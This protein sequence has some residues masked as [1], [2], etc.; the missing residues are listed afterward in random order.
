MYVTYRTRSAH[1]HVVGDLRDLI[2]GSVR[3]V[4]PG[5]RAGIG[6]QDHASVVLAR[7]D[8]GLSGE[9][10]EGGTQVSV[11][12]GALLKESP[13]RSRASPRARGS[14]GHAPLWRSPPSSPGPRR[15]R[16]ILRTTP[17]LVR[18]APK[19]PEMARTEAQTNEF[20]E[21]E[22]ERRAR[23]SRRNALYGPTAGLELF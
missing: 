10:R 11:R 13:A 21:T 14:N 18:S 23:R 12:S 2:R 22:N 6:A 4:R 16:G 5:G 1:P 7:H 17:W 20:R 9:A 19:M 8:G 3:D 15:A